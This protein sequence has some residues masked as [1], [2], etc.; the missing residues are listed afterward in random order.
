[1]SMMRKILISR[2]M[3]PGNFQ[4]NSKIQ[5]WSK[6]INVTYAMWNGITRYLKQ[7]VHIARTEAMKNFEI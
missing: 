4:A 2:L 1:M 7:I 5:R 3:R 6:R